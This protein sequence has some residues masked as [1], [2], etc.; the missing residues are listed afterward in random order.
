MQTARWTFQP[1]TAPTIAALILFP[2]LLL[3]GFWQLDRAD[4][5]ERLFEAYVQRATLGPVDLNR[6]E[7]FRESG[8]EMLWRRCIV[9]GHYTGDRVFL[10]DNQV[11]NGLAGYFVFNPFEIE[12]SDIWVMVNRGW[13]SAGGYRDRAPAIMTSQEQ[14]V[15]TGLAYL[16]SSIPMPANGNNVERMVQGVT[17]MQEMDTEVMEG[18]LGHK[19]LPYVIRLDPASPTG[20]ARVWP[21]PESGMERHMGYAFQWFALAATLLIIYVSV[22]LRR[23]EGAPGE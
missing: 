16:P 22:N 15:I 20:Y 18:L 1:G 10:L 8:D 21:E 9:K 12:G 3:L 11:L 13:V 19:L 4:Q 6:E 7:S 17:R 14:V 5:K 2:L 23:G